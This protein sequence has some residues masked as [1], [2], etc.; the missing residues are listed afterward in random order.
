MRKKYLLGAVVGVLGLAFAAVA[1]ASPQF[2][3]TVKVKYTTTNKAKRATGLSLKFEATDPGA[4]PP[5]NQPGATKVV[6]KLRGARTN[7]RA[8]KR[9]TLSKSNAASCPSNTRVDVKG[10]GKAS[11]N[12]VGTNPTTGQTTVTGPINN[13]VKAFLKRGGLYVVVQNAALGVNV[14]LDTSLSKRGTLTANVARDVPTLPGGNKLVLT[15]FQVKVKKVTRRV[16][17]KRI[18]LLRTPRCG[19]SKKFKFTTSFNYDD[20][21]S[22]TVRTSQRCRR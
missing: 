8:G 14:V 19:S 9:C 6:L 17:G 5:G 1:I 21:T 13:T 7:T 4:V 15:S 18:A 3:Q 11:A 16:S 20:G 22:K 2:K 12:I 10:S